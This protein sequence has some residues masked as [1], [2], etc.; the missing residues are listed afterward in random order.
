MEIDAGPQLERTNEISPAATDE[1]LGAAAAGRG[2]IDGSLDRG[3][4]ERDPVAHRA[5][6]AD[7]ED[8]QWPPIFPANERQG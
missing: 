2:F 6:F 7:I 4:I 3:G 8:G 1:H 5:E